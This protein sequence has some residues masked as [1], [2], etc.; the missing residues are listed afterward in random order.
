VIYRFSSPVD[1]F[2]NYDTGS[3]TLT[4]EK[5]FGLDRLILLLTA[6]VRK[7]MGVVAIYR[8]VLN[9]FDYTMSSI[10]RNP[11]VDCRVPRWRVRRG[12]SDSDM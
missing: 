6:D 10:C 3:L 2:S 11:K 1:G 8:T 9:G 4:D 12:K 7:W 5:I